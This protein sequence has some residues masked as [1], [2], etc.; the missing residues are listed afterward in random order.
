[1][2]ANFNGVKELEDVC[3]AVVCDEVVCWLSFSDAL[4]DG[5]AWKKSQYGR[6]YDVSEILTG[7]SQG[8]VIE[9]RLANFK[10]APLVSI[11]L[12]IRIDNIKILILRND[13]LLSSQLTHR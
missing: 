4:D 10:G 3:L 13:K 8:I 1:M 7:S 11:N 9:S 6:R 12:C 5:L 2:A